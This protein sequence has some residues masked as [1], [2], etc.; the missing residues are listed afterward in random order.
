M[1]PAK[2]RPDLRARLHEVPHKPGVY[3]MRDRLGRVIYVGKARDLRKRLAQYFTPARSRLADLKTRA[4]LDSVWDFSLHVVRS[5]AEAVL[6]EG[7]LIKEYRPKY[8]VSFRD[9]KNFL[10]LKVNLD[11]PFPRFTLVRLKKNDGARYYGPYAHSGALRA[12]LAILQRK[13]GLRSCRPRVPGEK[14]YRHCHDDIIKNCSAPCIGKISEADYRA[15]VLEACAFLEGRSKE[16]PGELEEE[17]RAAAAKHDFEKAAALRDLITA[18]RRTAAR[19]RRF[20]RGDSL[21]STQD[22]KGDLAALGEALGLGRP[23]A[24]MECFDISNITATHIV[25]SMVRFKD[26]VPDRTNYRRY[27]IRTVKGQDDFASMAEVVRR[28]YSWLLAQAREVGSD[29]AEFSQEEPGEAVARLRLPDSM[30]LPDL[31]IVDGGRGQLSS[32]CAELARLGL[33]GQPVIGLAKEREEIYFPHDPQPLRLP[34]DNGALQ[35]LQRIRDEAHRVANSYH[36]LLMKRRISESRLDDIE[37]INASRK[38]ALL[39]AFGSVERLRR[40]PLEEIAAV[41]GMGPRLAGEIKGA[42]GRDRAKH[43][44]TRRV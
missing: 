31:I 24:V 41:P 44:H 9:D 16:I 39:R 29:E 33:R 7:R 11:D 32:A 1:P 23:P 10:Q 21:P 14:D 3:L 22:P 36:R 4:L 40:A 37:G 43:L 25:A 38:K 12:T 30:R 5:D 28:R 8:N 19:S 27:R 15:R 17:M 13:F 34:H 6:L 18:L 42:L 35:M 26:G 20:L 2:E